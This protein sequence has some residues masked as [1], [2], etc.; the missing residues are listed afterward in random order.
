MTP[1]ICVTHVNRRLR[2]LRE[3]SLLQELYGPTFSRALS[4]APSS[5]AD[6]ASRHVSPRC[7]FKYLGGLQALPRAYSCS[8]NNIR[9]EHR[10]HSHQLAVLPGFSNHP[11]FFTYRATMEIASRTTSA[12]SARNN[13]SVF[14]ISQRPGTV[15][16]TVRLCDA[17]FL[18]YWKERRVRRKKRE[19][20]R[21][22]RRIVAWSHGCLRPQ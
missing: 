19:R 7:L 3:F 5:R 12:S 2:G 1:R 11:N 10:E 14:C 4:V 22:L 9:L 15:T 18:L 17:S 6:I 16:A 8:S 21:I 20:D 13:R